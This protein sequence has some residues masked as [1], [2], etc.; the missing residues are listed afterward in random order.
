MRRAADHNLTAID[1]IDARLPRLHVDIAAAAQDRLHLPANH[2]H[3][4]RAIHG[5]RFALY[6]PNRIARTI[7]RPRH[8]PR[9]ASGKQERPG[10]WDSSAARYSVMGRAGQRFRSPSRRWN[11]GTLY[12]IGRWKTATY[13]SRNPRR[14]SARI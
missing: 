1:Q 9:Q 2:L 12:T 7:V 10:Q 5:D 13:R 6:Y 14:R 8:R 3:G 11:G 4:H